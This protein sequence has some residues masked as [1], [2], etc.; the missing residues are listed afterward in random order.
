MKNF[1]W[2][3]FSLSILCSSMTQAGLLI[4]PNI[5]INLGGKF[6][7]DTPEA[8]VETFP[9]TFEEKTW[10]V[11]GNFYGLKLGYKFLGFMFGAE[12][13][14]TTGSDISDGET[15]NITETGAFVG[16]AFPFFLRIYAGPVLS[17]NIAVTDK[18]DGIKSEWLFN[19]GTGTRM[20]LGLT[21]L[22]FLSINLEMK[23]VKYK[24]F[25]YQYD[26]KAI[27]DTDAGELLGITDDWA[28]HENSL[29]TY[30]LSVSIP[31][32]I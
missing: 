3:C 19:G 10:D 17:S 32:E 9:D 5:G 1:F 27:W 21:L 2:C 6:S 8:F 20:G 18:E 4:E 14:Q 22:P 26:G 16:Y 15:F 13:S 29:T 31:I 24:K 25:D 12:Y 30:M 7:G 11:N 28:E 23:N